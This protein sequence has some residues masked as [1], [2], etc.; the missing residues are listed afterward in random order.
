[1]PRDEVCTTKKSADAEGVFHNCALST[2][3]AKH[4]MTVCRRPHAGR[5]FGDRAVSATIDLS[6][7]SPSG[8]VD[9]PR[10]GQNGIGAVRPRQYSTPNINRV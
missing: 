5:G 4:F 8:H 9:R 2:Q 3:S 6:K 7:T 10:T 1:M